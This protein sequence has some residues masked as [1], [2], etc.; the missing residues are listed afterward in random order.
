MKRK[1][2]IIFWT[3]FLLALCLVMIF[4]NNPVRNSLLGATSSLQ[5]SLWQAGSNTSEFL[6]AI[7]KSQGLKT[8]NEDLKTENI[9][10][11]SQI[12][13]LKIAQQDNIELKKA[14]G[15]QTDK[16]WQVEM[17][18]IVSKDQK[19]DTLIIDKGQKQDLAKDMPVITAEGALV[20]KIT[21]A[22]SDFSEVTLISETDFSFNI[23]IQAENN[24]SGVARGSGGFQVGFDYIPKDA[25]IKIGDLITTASMNE[26]FPRGLLVGEIG[27]LEKSDAEPYQKGAIA[28]FFVQ[29]Q[30][31][32]LFVVR[33]Y[34]P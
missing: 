32:T 34:S 5:K 14:L 9:A 1:Y 25:A 19:R 20:G 24:P 7:L 22:F 30:L 3:L 11:K 6:G 26:I 16:K 15:L 28:P 21:E 13:E 2:K 4:W 17:V 12:S 31:K 29:S 18:N 8:E 23:E 27:S 33:R 10:L